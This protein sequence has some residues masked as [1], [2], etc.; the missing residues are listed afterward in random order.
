MNC[1]GGCVGGGGQP[2]CAITQLETIKNKRAEGLYN[3]DAN[4][5]VRCAHDNK[6][7]KQ[8]INN[9]EIKI[10][11]DFKEKTYFSNKDNFTLNLLPSNIK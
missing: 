8:L 6:E 10:H 2:L 1:K 7:L 3:S 11:K 9:E 4:K 5:A